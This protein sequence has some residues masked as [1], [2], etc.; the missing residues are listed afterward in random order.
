M[1]RITWLKPEDRLEVEFQQLS[2]EGADPA[3]IRRQWERLRQGVDDPS[4]LRGEAERLLDECRALSDA[5]DAAGA[6]GR[7]PSD[8]EDILSTADLSPA[9]A[10]RAFSPELLNDHT[11]GGWMGRIA[12]CLLG[13]PMEGV[14]RPG[15]SA[16]LQNSAQWPLRD[17]IT[18][19]GVPEEITAR[20]PFNRTARQHSLRE[21]IVCMPEDDDINYTMLALYVVESAGEEFTTDDVATAWLRMLPALRVFTAERVAYQNLLD[22]L[23]PPETAR[24][25]NPY[26]EWI[27]AQ[28]RAD[29]FGWIAPGDP[30]RA[31]ELA[32][33][34]ARL[35]HVKNGIYGAMFVAAMVAA[36]CVTDDV[37]EVIAAGLSVLPRASRLAEAI[38]FARA[39]PAQ[40]ADYERALDRAYE[41]YDRYHWV[42]T[43]NNA[44]VVVLALLYSGGDYEQGIGLA[45]VGGWDTDCNG[46]TVGSI[47]GTMLGRRGVSAKWAAP[48][49]DRVRSSLQGFDNSSIEQLIGRTVRCVPSRYLTPSPVR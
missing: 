13:K 25:R 22:S 44:V 33:R 36:A 49:R 47:L 4:R 38:R 27:G 37:D 29:L 41:Q 11:G 45:V 15:I 14:P 9:L 48:L 23:A 16:I 40:A 8:L 35:S 39:L 5:H 42:H 46:A 3:P 24:F 34:D 12:G 30:R 7:E 10:S 43:I 28:I 26:R 20:F 17:Y 31:A 19:R 6:A 1:I 18:A 32:W 2:E 21:T